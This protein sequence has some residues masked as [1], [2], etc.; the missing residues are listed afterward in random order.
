MNPSVLC[1]YEIV[2]L[3]DQFRE[4]VGEDA[5]EGHHEELLALRSPCFYF[6]E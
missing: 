5:V 1:L 4:V 2:I 6:S 3:E